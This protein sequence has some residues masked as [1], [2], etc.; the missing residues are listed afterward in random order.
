MKISL[1]SLWAARQKPPDFFPF[2]LY[3]N[4]RIL[5]VWAIGSRFLRGDKMT[6]DEAKK[7][8]GRNQGV[9]LKNMHLALSMAR[10]NNTTE[11]ERRL[12]AACNLLRKKYTPRLNGGAIQ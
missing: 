11:E 12:E 8:C 10:W 4:Y 6:L 7:I 1:F 5:V 9:F 2:P 3:A